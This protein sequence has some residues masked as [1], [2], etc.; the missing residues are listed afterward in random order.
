[1]FGEDE[2]II[3]TRANMNQNS[4]FKAKEKSYVSKSQTTNNAKVNED[5]LDEFKSI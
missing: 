1:M 2:L 3:G 4:E 5:L